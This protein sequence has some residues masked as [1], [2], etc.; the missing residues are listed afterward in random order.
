MI[1]LTVDRISKF[2]PLKNIY[3][4]TTKLCQ[5]H[6][7]QVPEILRKSYTRTNDKETAACIDTG[8]EAS[9][10]DPEAVMI[11]LPSDHYIQEED[12]FIETLKQGLK[13][14]ESENCLVTMGIAYK[15]GN[16]L[17]YIETGRKIEGSWE[18]PTYKIK[19]LQKSQTGKRL[20][21]L[22]TRALFVEHGML[23]GKH[24]YYLSSI[25]ISSRYVSMLEENQ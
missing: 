21:S 12:M 4:V 2:I 9:K 8:G 20:R 18:I 14:A 19:D 17:R 1:Q 15:T 10:K 6:K 3:M 22:L 16:S 23:S 7:E 11:V 25:K 5:H 24:R 13:I